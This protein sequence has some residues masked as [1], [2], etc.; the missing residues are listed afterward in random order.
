MPKNLLQGLKCS[1]SSLNILNFEL[2]ISE[3]KTELLCAEL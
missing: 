1:D 3:E 2:V